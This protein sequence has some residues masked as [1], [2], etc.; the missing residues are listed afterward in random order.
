MFHVLEHI[1]HQIQTL[2]IIKKNLKKNG[3]LIIEVPHADDFLLNFDELK[4]FKDFTFWS[5]H[6]ILHT[7]FS[8]K[9][10]LKS[11]L[12]KYQN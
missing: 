9:K 1:P 12:Q 5:E 2:K 10:F 3:K 11:W 8:L 4:E 6:L 7:F